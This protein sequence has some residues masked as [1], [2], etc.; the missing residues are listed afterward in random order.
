MKIAGVHDVA[1]P[2]EQVWA[3]LQDPEVLV[4]T[5]PGCVS[6]ERVGEDAY[7]MTVSA[8][9]ASIKG[10]YTGSVSLE[11]VVG[12]EAYTMRARGQGAPGTVDA[13][14]R[15]TL[16]DNGDGSTRVA[17]DCDAV[18]GGTVGGVGQ[19]VLSGVA[20]RTAGEFFSAV[21]AH[22]SG[23][24][25]AE[26]TVPAGIEIAAGAVE[27]VQGAGPFA[28]PDGE[29]ARAYY[30]APPRPEAV[31]AGPF[32]LLAAAVVGA[33]IALAGVALGRRVR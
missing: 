1:A 30:R 33:A 22:L 5:I 9:V 16:A 32:W 23:A 2:K 21:E 26:V 11:D 6:L 27:G 29:R 20:K 19:R 15:I 25:P 18:I 8:G 28:P 7:R 31:P 12:G 13:T 14:T 10:T 3:A 4:R 17:Y 24:L